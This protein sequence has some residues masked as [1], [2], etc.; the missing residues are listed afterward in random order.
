MVTYFLASVP[1]RMI[2]S[3]GLNSSG[4]KLPKAQET[5]KTQ[6]GSLQLHSQTTLGSN[7]GPQTM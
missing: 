6:T 7:F 2:K 4:S 5:S 1:N 3:K